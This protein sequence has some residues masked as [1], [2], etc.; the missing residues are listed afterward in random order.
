MTPEY[1]EQ[2]SWWV[3]GEL[4]EELAFEHNSVV[5]M[6]L[7]D[8]RKKEGWIVGASIESPEVIFTVEACDGSGDFKCPQS[9]LRAVTIEEPIQPPQRNAGSRPSSDDSSA[10]ETPSSLG[11]RG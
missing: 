8:G 1:R 3:H 6:T 9:S 7:P 4:T 2:N 10:S 11:P 5:E